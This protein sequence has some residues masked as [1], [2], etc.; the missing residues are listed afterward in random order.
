MGI[1]AVRLTWLV[2][3]VRR[4]TWR[5]VPWRTAS[6]LRARLQRR[7]WMTAERVP[8]RSRDVRFGRPW[9]RVP[10]LDVRRRAA[11]CDAADALMQ[12]RLAVF[13]TDVPMPGGIPDWNADPVTGTRIAL[14]FGLSIDFRHMPGGVD[15]K[16]LWEVNR[17][18][19]WVRLAQAWAA[20]QDV[21]L[22]QRLGALIDDWTV[23]CPYARGA[24]WASPVEHGI[25]LVNWSLVWH[26]VG[27][28]TSALFAGE[29]GRARRERWLDCIY[30]HVR[31]AS[32]NYSFHSSADN[33]LIGEAAGVFVALHTWDCWPAARLLRDRAKRILEAETLKQFA[34]DGV[35]L[36]QATCYHKF[37]LQ[38]L[39]AAGLCARAV[40]D[41]LGAACWQ[42][43]EAAVTFLAAV[44]ECAGHV[45]AIGDS[46]DG[47]VWLLAD[48][49]GVRGHVAVLALGA[50]LF[51]RE[52]LL[53]KCEAIG[54]P[55]AE[56]AAW[57]LD[58]AGLAR[59]VAGDAPAVSAALPTWFPDGG[60]ALLGQRLHERDELRVLVD[61]GP[62]GYNRIAG[63]GHADALSVLVSSAGEQ[64][65]VDAG[66][67]CYNAAPALR[68]FFR[69][70][71]AHNTLE[72]DGEDQSV[73][74]ASFLWL[75][76]VN[77]TA[78][79]R[80]VPAGGGCVEASHD[81]YLRLADPVRHHRRVSVSDDGAIL[82]E[83]W[84]DCRAPHRVV[85]A[86]HGAAGTLLE[87]DTEGPGWRL[88]GATRRLAIACGAGKGSHGDDAADVQA[89]AV[90][91]SAAPPQGWVSPA[92]YVRQA[93]PALL[94]AATLVPGQ[95]LR[96][97]MTVAAGDTA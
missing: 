62:L 96:T 76:D 82:V 71:S 29:A 43:I 67:Y 30:R 28:E 2:R 42:R 37:S 83:D 16:H 73:Y 56:R 92:F 55:A 4:M 39:L 51:A 60:Y 81:G 75:R 78:T 69:G 65:L 57:L 53:A 8:A 80:D 54:H 47:E 23:Q 17:H 48:A 22:L 33:H 86:W 97:R 46:D 27:G 70:T 52:D 15:I 12:G 90:S 10:T 50:A 77:C 9:C 91:G 31:F 11:V 93:A 21:A 66:T 34:A 68:H 19:W 84:L 20:S 58:P 7:G 3:R 45:P 61:C 36:E 14:D 18:V 26:L 72:V 40:G 64:L 74:G 85:Q 49:P 87:R 94:F 88:H 63:H 1:D 79:R 38:F 24:N 44:T 6:V 5:E 25:R 13:G 59:I 95:V 35:N 89:S 41:D 32:D